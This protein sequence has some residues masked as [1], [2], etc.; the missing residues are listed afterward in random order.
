MYLKSIKIN[1]LSRLLITI[2]ILWIICIVVFVTLFAVG[3]NGFRSTI[4]EA[5]PIA[6]SAPFTF[7]LLSSILMGFISFCLLCLLGIVKVILANKWLKFRK[8]IKGLLIFISKF[9]LVLCVLPIFVIWKL[10]REKGTT[11][12]KRLIKVLVVA[13]FILPIWAVVYF[14]I[15]KTAQYTLGYVPVDT[16]IVGTG[17]MYPTW[18]KG[19]KDKDPKELAKEIVDSAGFLPYPNGVVIGGNRIL[20]HTLGRGDIIIWENDATREL[21]S[22]DGGEP[23]GLLKRIIGLPGDTIEIRDGVVYLNEEPQKEPYIASPH[24]TFGEKFLRECQVVTVPQDAVFAMGDNRKGSADS[25]KIGFAPIKDIRSVLPLEKQKGKLDENWRDASND[26]AETTKPKI[27]VDRFVTLLN[28]KREENGV[29]L[30]KHEP[31]LDQSA[32]IRAKYMLESNNIEQNTSY[33]DITNAMNKAGYWNNYVWEVRVE[34]YYSADELI[35]DYLERNWNEN[36]NTW[37]DKTFDDIGIAE[38]QATLNGCPT[39]LIVVH[40][41]GYVPP[42]YKQSDIDS[43]QQTL[44][45]LRNIQGG[46]SSL[47]DNATYYQ[48]NKPDIDRI[49]EIISTRISRIDVIVTTMK[50]NQWL[51]S[52]QNSWIN[53]DLSLYNEQESLATKLNKK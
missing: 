27:D 2:F 50:A 11:F 26:L 9:F 21:T 5:P 10:I 47:K 49:N 18:P 1:S 46:W 7:V 4:D 17:S 40:A 45:A 28:H 33:E 3:T 20:G 32:A 23:A 41:A 53:Q 42:D 44:D 37:Y 8:S 38:V 24:S 15:A 31:E 22:K 39:Q 6:N 19:S 35:E 16:A 13:I 36:K 29:T 14:G 48:A 43:W 51:S 30:I 34:G 25:R 52:Q 12:P